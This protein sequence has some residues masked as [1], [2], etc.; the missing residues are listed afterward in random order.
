MIW[1]GRDA[2]M[3]DHVVPRDAVQPGRERQSSEL[4]AA[5][6]L[7]HLEE[8]FLGQILGGLAAAVQMPQ[9]VPEDL[10]C[11]LL[12]ELAKRPAVAGLG[13]LYQTL[14]QDLRLVSHRVAFPSTWSI[15]LARVARSAA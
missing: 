1:R 10:W 3:V 7:Q 6:A 8:H 4:V 9:Q 13:P 11:E 12:V 14:H 2:E 15:T 5:Q